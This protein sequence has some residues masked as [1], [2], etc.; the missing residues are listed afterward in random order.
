M[1]GM[2]SGRVSR[3]FTYNGL[4]S[5]S[6]KPKNITALFSSAILLVF[7]AVTTLPNQ[8]RADNQSA[9]AVIPNSAGYTQVAQNQ[10]SAGTQGQ[11]ETVRPEVPAVRQG[12]VLTPRGVLVVEPSFEYAHTSVDRFVF[13]GVEIVDTVLLG[14]INASQADRDVITTSLGF[15]YG[16][17]NRFEVEAK[18]P[19]VYRHDEATDLITEGGVPE[20]RSISSNDLG[21]VELGLHFQLNDGPIY[22]VTNLRVKSNTGT[23][24]FDVGRDPDDGREL[25]LATGS[26]F[27][28]VEPSLTALF[29]SDPA[30][31]YGNIGYL[32]NIS[33]DVDTILRPNSADP[34]TVG[35][36]HPGDA[37]RTSF[38]M[39]FALNEKASFSIGYQ[40]DFINGT[41]TVTSDLA[42][43]VAGKGKRLNVGAMTFGVNYQVSNRTGI[44]L[45][46]QS[47]VTDDAPDVRVLLRIPIAVSLF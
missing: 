11:A 28:G 16:V 32:W 20:E 36:V 34:V 29:P 17:T 41:T 19:W 47:G 10:T 26:G 23:G 15:R 30:V 35:K 12:G 46:V 38:G 22:L 3:F 24:P 1:D 31:F 5:K 14:V 6:A 18:V 42:G 9:P 25:E 33:D 45:S 7:A 37:V 21:D 8:A 44:N 27:W 13:Q 2:K 39:G 43:T 4:A 40:N